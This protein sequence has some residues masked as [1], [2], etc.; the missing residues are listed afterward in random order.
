MHTTGLALVPNAII[1]V[2]DCVTLGTKQNLLSRPSR[3][4]SV[5][6]TFDSSDFPQQ[7]D[8]TSPLFLQDFVLQ[9]VL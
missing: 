1:Q 9:G 5:K 2:E 4:D 7:T 8:G 6:A 3:P